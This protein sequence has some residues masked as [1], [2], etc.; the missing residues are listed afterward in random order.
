MS[1]IRMEAT[2]M[3]MGEAAGIAAAQA[4]TEQVP[5]Q[6][7]DRRRL[8]DRLVQ[9]GQILEWDGTGYGG[10]KSAWWNKRP[11]D[12]RRNPISSIQKGLREDSEFVQRFEASRSNPGSLVTP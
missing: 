5:V 10:G 6:R 1:S 12:Y 7:I 11:E 8:R 9:V 2:W 4:L 3:L